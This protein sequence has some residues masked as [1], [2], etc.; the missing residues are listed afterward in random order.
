[1]PLDKQGSP[2]SFAV[3]DILRCEICNI[4]ADTERLTLNMIG[5]YNKSPDLKL[6][7]CDITELPKYYR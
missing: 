6:G 5:M 7:L 1:M 2:R 3:N 4:S